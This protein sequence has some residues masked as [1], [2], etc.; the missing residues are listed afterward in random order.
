MESPSRLGSIDAVRGLAVV[1]MLFHHFTEYLLF[2]PL[3]SAVYIICFIITRIS[4]PLFLVVSGISMTL[5]ASRRARSQNRV[6]IAAHFV[7]RGLLLIAAGLAI[8]IITMD[9]S[10]LNILIP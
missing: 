3:N 7:K 1:L 10:H 6:D 9:Y 5:S 8:N 4:A 2:N